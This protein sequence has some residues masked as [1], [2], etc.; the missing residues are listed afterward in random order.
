M[1]GTSFSQWLNAIQTIGG[2]NPQRSTYYLIEVGAIILGVWSCLA[3]RKRY[4]GISWYGLLAITIALTS[5]P[6]QGMH[7]HILAAPSVFIFLGRLGQSEA[8]DRAWTIASV[9]LMGM[10]A[11]LFSFDFWV[12]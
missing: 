9:L 10:L 4:P 3:T 5:G 6:A 1:V 8:F 7:R 12:G 2:D 11:M